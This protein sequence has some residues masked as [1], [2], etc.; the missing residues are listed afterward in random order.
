MR[1]ISPMIDLLLKL[2][3]FLTVLLPVMVLFIGL[4]KVRKQDRKNNLKQHF[5][6][7]CILTLYM[8]AVFFFTGAGTVF[9]IF[10]NTTKQW[11]VAKVNLLPFAKG[12]AI[13]PTLLNI[14]LFVPFGFLL[15]LLWPNTGK[16]WRVLLFGFCLSLLIE[17][18]QYYSYR[19]TDVEDLM[20]NTFGAVVGYLL[21]K[22]FAHV[23]KWK[24][25]RIDYPK[26]EPLV[27][28]AAMFF[29]HFLLY[30][31]V[32]LWTILENL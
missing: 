3:E 24:S 6:L 10:R 13:R 5:I 14:L 18:S 29:G 19:T 11:Y 25:K 27:Y 4:N 20:M 12:I 32:G 9:D 30:N 17:L 28:V 21:Y 1:E 2:Y 15:P 7:L 31:S 22:L 8:F 23:S 26:Y 16:L